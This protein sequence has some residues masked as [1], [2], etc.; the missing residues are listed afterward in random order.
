VTHPG[1]S[2]IHLKQQTFPDES[3]VTAAASPT[4]APRSTMLQRNRE[5]LHATQPEDGGESLQP[6]R[7]LQGYSAPGWQGASMGKNFHHLKVDMPRSE[8]ESGADRSVALNGCPAVA[9]A[10]WRGWNA[11]FWCNH[12]HRASLTPASAF[13]TI[14]RTGAKLLATASICCRT[15]YLEHGENRMTD[16]GV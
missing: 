3:R 14:A 2:S 5:C 16:P 10:T 8:V 6:R 12:D 15:P 11:L 13:P 9:A 7:T 4:T 1:M